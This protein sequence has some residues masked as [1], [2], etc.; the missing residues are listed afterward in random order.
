LYLQVTKR[1]F[2][3]MREKN[4]ESSNVYTGGILDGGE[5]EEME[6]SGWI[7]EIFSR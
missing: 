7:Q 6:E 3:D 5:V 4:V 2:E 1:S